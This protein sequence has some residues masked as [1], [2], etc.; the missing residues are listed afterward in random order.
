MWKNVIVD[1]GEERLGYEFKCSLSVSRKDASGLKAGLSDGIITRG[2][3]V[4]AGE[5]QFPLTDS[6]H[7]MPAQ[8]LLLS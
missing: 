7:A 3:V 2:A 5:R 1:R 4:Y 6:I 8:Q